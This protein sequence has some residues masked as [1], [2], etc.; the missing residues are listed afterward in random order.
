MPRLV[1]PLKDAAS[2]AIP[3]AG[4]ALPDINSTIRGKQADK[5]IVAAIHYLR[6]AAESGEFEYQLVSK[7]EKVY[8][9]QSIMGVPIKLTAD[10]R[11]WAGNTIDHYEIEIGPVTERR[12]T[13]KRLVHQA[14]LRPVMYKTEDLLDDAV[15][16]GRVNRMP[17]TATAST[18][19]TSGQE[20]V[21]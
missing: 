18:P 12:G 10:H 15:A 4:H 20:V 6:M 1:Q 19:A 16:E 2:A 14:N 9:C 17:Q 3:G 7:N 8:R 11:E 21:Q 5:L 13:F